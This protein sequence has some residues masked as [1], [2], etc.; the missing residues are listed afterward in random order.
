MLSAEIYEILIFEMR[1]YHN[2]GAAMIKWAIKLPDSSGDIEQTNWVETEDDYTG[3]LDIALLFPTRREAVAGI[4]EAG[5][6]AVK[7]EVKKLKSGKVKVREI[8]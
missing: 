5:E 6:V 1:E 4:T 8:T 3:C 7:V 2:K